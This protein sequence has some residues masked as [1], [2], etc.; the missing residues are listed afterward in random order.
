MST[1]GQR[2]LTE[3]FGGRVAID[4]DHSSDRGGGTRAAAWI[5]SLHQQ[6]KLVTADVEFTPRGAKSVRN[7]DY[8]YISPTF[9][10]NYTDEHGER[11]GKAL[12]GAALTNR[13]VLRRECPASASPAT[14]SRASPRCHSNPRRTD[15]P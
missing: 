7:G 4:Y 5:T 11:H 3:T 9:V 12:I 2:N 6:G 10:N 14:C 1:V 13:P 8:K 15:A